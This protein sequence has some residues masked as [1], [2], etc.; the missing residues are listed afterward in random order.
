MDYMLLSV[1]SAVVVLITYTVTVK[2]AKS[3]ETV[4]IK[5]VVHKKI[6]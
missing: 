4:V 6:V 2:I 1:Y 5:E 3:K